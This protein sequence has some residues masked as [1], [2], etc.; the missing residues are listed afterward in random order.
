MF[1]SPNTAS[2]MNSVPASY[3]GVA[4]GMKSTLQNAGQI[5]SL[6][7]FLTIV[8]SS[9]S[10]SL[11]S[12]LSNAMVQAV[13]PQLAPIFQKNFRP[14]RV[15]LYV[16]IRRYISLYLRTHSRAW[17]SAH[18]ELTSSLVPLRFPPVSTHP[19]TMQWGAPTIFSPPASC[20]CTYP[21]LSGGLGSL[22][23]P[24]CPCTRM[25]KSGDPYKPIY[26]ETADYGAFRRVFGLQPNSFNCLAKS[27][28]HSKRCF[29]KNHK[30]HL[31]S[32][33]DSSGVV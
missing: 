15:S 19:P 23:P 13:A 26:F 21:S 14:Q 32:R 17:A 18:Q 27:F 12:A 11:P 22:P 28:E 4:S 20:V 16:G 5:V 1:S 2:I 30:Q 24:Y 7:M 9:L 29:T 33:G 8:I 25:L 10:A 31:L 6:A 3:R